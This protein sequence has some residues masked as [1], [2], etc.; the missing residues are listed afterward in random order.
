MAENYLHWLVYH[1][2][3]HKTNSLVYGFAAIGTHGSL[4]ATLRLVRPSAGV[5]T[6]MRCGPSE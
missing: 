5:V 3:E 4:M 1:D 6:S 2:K